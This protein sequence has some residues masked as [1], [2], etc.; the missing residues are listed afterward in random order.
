MSNNVILWNGETPNQKFGSDK[1]PNGNDFDILAKNIM[2]NQKRLGAGEVMVAETFIQLSPQSNQ[3]VSDL[4]AFGKYYAY[5]K[6]DKVYLYTRKK[7]LGSSYIGKVSC[8]N[9]ALAMNEDFIFILDYA[10]DTLT[11]Y[12]LLD[13]SKVTEIHCESTTAKMVASKKHVYIKVSGGAI[14]FNTSLEQVTFIECLDFA[15]DV[16]DNI[17]TFKQVAY[18]RYILEA[19]GMEEVLTGVIMSK[20]LHICGENVHFYYREGTSTYKSFSWGLEMSIP[21]YSGT[22]VENTGLDKQGCFWY[23]GGDIS[24]KAFDGTTLQAKGDKGKSLLN[25][26]ISIDGSTLHWYSREVP[27]IISRLIDLTKDL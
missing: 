17:A 13:F 7:V 12:N 18:H 1:A 5:E 3:H 2:V 22:D 27:T 23:N 21:C 20:V 25:G 15:V 16:D 19:N 9:V 6:E 26:F 11:A 14:V 10:A 24:Y 8:G 4:V